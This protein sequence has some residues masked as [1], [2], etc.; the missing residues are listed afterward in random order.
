MLDQRRPIGCAVRINLS[1]RGRTFVVL[2]AGRGNTREL[3]KASNLSPRA[4]STAFL[5][6][7]P[8]ILQQLSTPVLEDDVGKSIPDPRT[9]I[10]GVIEVVGKHANLLGYLRWDGTGAISITSQKDD[11]AV[12]CIME[13]SSGQAHQIMMVRRCSVLWSHLLLTAFLFVPQG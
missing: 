3:E 10:N 13:H 6:R 7:R 12:G 8:A 4:I 9:G 1:Q 11:A 5:Y 2:Q